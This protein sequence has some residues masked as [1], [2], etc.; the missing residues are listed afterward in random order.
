MKI[1]GGTT[2]S[3]TFLLELRLLWKFPSELKSLKS[4]GRCKAMKIFGGSKAIVKNLQGTKP[5][6]KIFGGFD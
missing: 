1:F 6:A 5:I 2:A 4:F 3:L